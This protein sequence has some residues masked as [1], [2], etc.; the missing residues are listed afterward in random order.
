[1]RSARRASTEAPTVA[2]S[3]KPASER[4][5]K[6]NASATEE[7]QPERKP[8]EVV[9][10]YVIVS[11]I[12]AG[13]MGTVYAAYD[14]QLDRKVALKFL[15]GNV[16][17]QNTARLLRE[18]Q[19]MA[20]LPHPNVVPVHDVG[21]DRGDVFLA[22]EFVDGGT[23]ADWLEA[24]PRSF[25]DI[26]RVFL[27][28]G[29]GLAAAHAAGLVHR[30]FKPTN[31]LID[32]QGRVLVTDFGLVCLD[33]RT[34]TPAIA[35]PREL[36]P[37]PT[38]SSPLSSPLTQ[39]GNIVG[40]PAFMAPEQF[41]GFAD[42]RSDQ[43]CFC[44]S[45]YWA[46]YQ[47]L[48][49]DKR[50]DARLPPLR[51]PPAG[52]RVPRWIRQVLARGLS[53]S[54]NARYP[55][56]QELLDALGHDPARERRRWLV[57]AGAVA[58]IG[59]VM[60]LTV[61]SRRQ[62]ERVCAGA[63]QKLAGVWNTGRKD[64]IRHAFLAS[65][66]PY[67][68]DMV[69]TVTDMLDD[70]ARD[71]AA[72]HQSA[73][74]ATRVRGEQSEELLDLRME[75][76]RERQRELGSLVELFS[77]ADGKLVQRAV[78]AT[79]ALTPLDG[80]ANTAALKTP[81]RMPTAPEA[82]AQ[83]EK[84]LD[85]IARGR[86][87]SASGRY[88]ELLVWSKAI[89]DDAKAIHHEP[90]RARALHL[91]GQAQLA[92]GDN[93]GAEVTL[94][95]GL[96]AA[97]AGRDDDTAARV[98]VELSNTTRETLSHFPESLA[99]TEH[100]RA[101]LERSGGQDTSLAIT[102]ERSTGSLLEMWGKFAEARPHFER[103]L[104]LAQ[105]I[106]G[107]ESS[108]VGI[109]LAEVGLV[110]YDLAKYD[111]ALDYLQRAL[112]VQEKAVGTKHPNVGKTLNNLSMV[113]NEL[114]RFRE[115]VDALTRAQHI[116][117]ASYPPGHRVLAAITINLGAAY[118]LLGRYDDALQLLREHV[119][120]E[121]KSLGPDHP[122]VADT[123]TILGSVL[124][125]KG[126]YTEA[127]PLEQEALAIQEKAYRGP[128]PSMGDA[129][130]GIGNAYLGMHQPDKAV[131]PLERGNQLADVQT[132]VRGRIRLALAQALDGS[133]RG[134]VVR[135]R[136]LMLEAKK[137]FTLAPAASVDELAQ[138]TQWLRSHPGT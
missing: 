44:V 41:D 25:R 78:D 68:A 52:S 54:T 61:R 70:Y 60:G 16:S 5:P 91:Y 63:E 86:A 58:M 124:N 45:L 106:F 7:E 132:R 123:L 79:Q 23:V 138:I 38:D 130:L 33:G 95:E 29:R 110:S 50:D 85:R 111:V 30:D 87:I 59:A 101:W 114:G 39:A 133:K 55:S 49:F 83:V 11:V 10:R 20:K 1:V 9:G 3:G 51:D 48:P 99:W 28:A 105:K 97:E 73:C 47:Q 102:I 24:E 126:R 94:K 22:M 65:G 81:V 27:E 115:S 135:V 107:A 62:D 119:A 84:L 43:F 93:A 19:A 75:C 17:P 4:A 40:T 18:A 108:Q 53:A 109:G 92:N 100:A 69:R 56:M 71:W 42:A 6:R 74:Q 136:D 64:A 122:D 32:K 37:A 112:A 134:D 96:L 103:E 104:E 88:V 137:D 26:L 131:A 121:K 31:L 98:C 67:A 66:K 72:M 80:C 90:T 13:G 46:L 118:E 120:S 116:F 117:E 2:D 82:R 14:P 125:R 77:S 57:A 8:G 21:T 113:D 89:V 128:H 35:P 34:P 129:L 36:P 15:Q 76:L 12:G 127:L